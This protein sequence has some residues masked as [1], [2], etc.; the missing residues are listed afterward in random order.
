MVANG[1]FLI[2]E[3][4]LTSNQDTAEGMFTLGFDRRHTE[5]TIQSIDSWGTYFVT[6]RGNQAESKRIKL[7][8]KDNDPHIQSL[9]FTKE[10]AYVLDF[11]DTNNFVIEV[12]M[13]D[14]RTDERQEIKMMEYDFSRK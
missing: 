11:R 7:Y 14:T 10:F 4:S 9:G 12:I 6:A 5:Y 1:G 2:C 13:I 3:Y 8:G